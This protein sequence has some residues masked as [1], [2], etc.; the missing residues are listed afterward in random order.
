MSA[1]ILALALAAAI[2][3]QQDTPRESRGEVSSVLPAAPAPVPTADPDVRAA[4]EELA[5]GRAWP[6]TRLVYR[7]VKEPERRTPEA[8]L[9]AARSAAAWRGWTLVNALLA[10]EPWLDSRFNGEGRELLARAA[11]E[12]G[13]A[14]AAREHAEA[15]LRARGNPAAMAARTVLLARALDRLD[16]RD[17]AAAA[18]RRGAELL[19]AVADWLH[20][21]AAGVTADARARERLYGGIRD[22]APRSR[23][24]HT[25]A[26]ALERFGLHQAAANEYEKLGDIPS[27]LRLRLSSDYDPALRSGLESTLLGYIQRDATGEN[28]GRAI[29][30][31]DAAFPTLDAASELLVARRAAQGGLQARAAQGF[32]K[33]PAAQLT[34][35]D[36][37]AW[38]R[39]LV[40]SGRPRDAAAMLGRRRFA[41][42]ASAEALY[43]RGLA[44]VRS[45]AV[46][47]ARPTLQRVVSAH[48][49]TRYAADALYLMADIETDAG[50]DVEAR[51]LHQRSCVHPQP[52]S[53]S[54]TACFRSGILSFALGNPR[55]AA[56]AFDQ[57]GARHPQSSEVTA[58]TYWAGRSHLASGDAAAARERF[59]SVLAREPLSYYATRAAVRMD[60]VPWLPRGGE[61]PAATPYRDVLQR[62]A[63]L[64]YLGMDVEERHEY[65]ALERAAGNDPSVA[66]AVGAALLERGEATRAL[67]LGWRV[68]TLARETRDSGGRYDERGY[69]LV[70]PV[71]HEVELVAR[72]RQNNL[73]P[74]LVAAVIRQESSWQPRALSRAGARGLM[75]IMPPVGEAI[76]RSKGYPVWD[77]ALLFD[78]DVSLELGTAH[79][80]AALSQYNN[81]PRALA[82]YNA[83]GSRVTRW[84]RRAG[85]ADPEV[86]IERIPFVETR[87][88]VRIVM[89]NVEMYRA[90][91]GLKP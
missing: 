47:A 59:R 86:F 60:T 76:A 36:A 37:I 41:A 70:Y 80:R 75:Q 78:P 40:G 57:L 29:Q 8:L 83:G 79:L 65:D 11:L 21:R 2:A 45:G 48:G 38:G 42:G 17:T 19:P 52:G 13:D 46:T 22:S 58:A 72:A 39:A 61:Q 34:D 33:V 15:A 53:W 32:A 24:A 6:A 87:D 68:V 35:A 67:R 30:V 51:I 20:L 14:A 5:E 84:S 7:A 49:A 81:L 82:A 64:E 90:I 10:Y 23:V 89:R 63:V 62:A 71:F 3:C 55:Q 69:R 18:Y 56:Q 77:A 31:L 25:E 26:Q 50:R 43:V 91:H 12:R 66:L 85:V 28:L 16:A 73:D 74:A 27:A 54:A 4:Q 1:P 88:Y 9:V 44:Q